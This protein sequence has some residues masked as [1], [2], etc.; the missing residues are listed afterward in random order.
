MIAMG[1][2]ANELTL[3]LKKSFEGE[4]SGS[5]E[6]VMKED[7]RR[8]KVSFVCL[9]KEG[10][11]GRCVRFKERNGGCTFYFDGEC[12]AINGAS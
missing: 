9:A 3:C 10:E 11:E 6:Q 12:G 1:Q 7:F 2:T 5:F 4:E 8:L